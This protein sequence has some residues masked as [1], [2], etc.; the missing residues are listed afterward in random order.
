[1]KTMLDRLENFMNQ[2]NDMDWGWWPLLSVRPPKDQYMSN[3]VLLKLA[4]FYGSIIG[5]LFLSV[6]ITW[7]VEALTFGEILSAAIICLLLGWTLAFITYKITIAYAWN[8]RARRLR[9]HQGQ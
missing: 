3:L 9:G 1:M 5:A 2:L 7:A 8:R 4:L 6:V